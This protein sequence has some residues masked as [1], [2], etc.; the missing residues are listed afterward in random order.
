LKRFVKLFHHEIDPKNKYK[1]QIELMKLLLLVII[2]AHIIASFWIGIGF[3]SNSHEANSWIESQDLLKH[4]WDSIYIRGLYFACM[5]MTTVGYGDIVPKTDL[6]H[7]ACI[8]I[9]LLACGIF[10]FTLNTITS[11]L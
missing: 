2:M 10:A 4:S 6:E 1:S 9:M 8:G 11:I 7:L 3:Y 5:T